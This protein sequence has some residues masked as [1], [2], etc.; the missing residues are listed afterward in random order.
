[1]NVS[2]C[3]QADWMDSGSGVFWKP[4]E[5]VEYSVEIVDAPRQEEDPFRRGE[6]KQRWILDIEVNGA[7]MKY[8]PG[9]RFLGALKGAYLKRPIW[10]L[11]V[12]IKRFGSGMNTSWS[13]AL[14]G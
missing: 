10:P 14:T 2:D 4:E 5:G 7:P 3:E 1:M 6:N 8:C 12:K 11:S 9:R 13:I